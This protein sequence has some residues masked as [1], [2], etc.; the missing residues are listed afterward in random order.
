MIHYPDY[1]A[2]AR[3][4]NQVDFSSTSGHVA[5][6][7]VHTEDDYVSRV[8]RDKH[9]WR[10]C[11]PLSKFWNRRGEEQT[12][13]KAN[14]NAEEVY[15]E[16]GANVGSC[17]MEMLMSTNANI[18]AFEPHP[19]NYKLLAATISMLDLRYQNRVALFPIGLGSGKSKSQIFSGVG[20]MGNSVVGKPLKDNPEQETHPPVDIFIERLDSILSDNIT[21]PL[22]KMDAQ[23][24]EC[25]ILDGLS[26]DIADNI[27]RLKFEYARKWLDGQGCVDLLPKLRSF[28]FAI[29]HED[30]RSMNLDDF[31]CGVCDLYA[32][33][34]NL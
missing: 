16:I 3:T 27:Q 9:R 29:T 28:G 4:C 31:N 7:C 25:Q 15:V 2:L 34:S 1:Q 24:L 13:K 19:A 17:V 32:I 18:V 5:K 21:I 10:Q 26:N 22:V 11:D 30:G 33:K 12:T 8:L 23:G 14:E 20:N 6:M